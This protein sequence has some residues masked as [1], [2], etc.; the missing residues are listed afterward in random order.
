[1]LKKRQ[2]APD[3]AVT[4]DLLLAPA[5]LRFPAPRDGSQ[6]SPGL[7]HCT[8]TARKTTDLSGG[9]SKYQSRTASEMGED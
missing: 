8:K 2:V 5:I 9:V 4:L 1:M 6:H 7:A 3:L